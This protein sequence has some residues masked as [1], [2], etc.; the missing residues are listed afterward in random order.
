M[1][2]RNS[3]TPKQP[4]RVLDRTTLAAVAG[5]AGRNY[6]LNPPS[7]V[8]YI[9]SNQGP[10]YQAGARIGPAMVPSPVITES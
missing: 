7:A 10:L 1:F 5:G 2:T 6:E 4:M 9:W 8:D 3:V